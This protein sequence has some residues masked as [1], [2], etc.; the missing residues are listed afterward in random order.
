MFPKPSRVPGDIHPTDSTRGSVA[1]ITPEL[2]TRSLR[3]KREDH[4]LLWIGQ[5]PQLVLA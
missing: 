2:E 4:R 1:W 5:S 3:L